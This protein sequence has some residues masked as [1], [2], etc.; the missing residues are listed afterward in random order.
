MILTIVKNVWVF[1][2]SSRMAKLSNV[3]NHCKSVKKSISGA[4]EAGNESIMGLWSQK[5]WF[6]AL[7]MS[8][9]AVVDSVI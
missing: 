8:V 9:K 3:S 1:E 7:E 4:F 2:T 6:R 5:V